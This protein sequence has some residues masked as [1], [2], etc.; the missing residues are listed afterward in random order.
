MTVQFVK[1]WPEDARERGT[2]LVVRYSAIQNECA[3]LRPRVED[4]SQQI[5]D[6]VDLDT[7][8]LHFKDE[9][10]MIGSCLLHPDHVVEQE[11]VAVAW[12]QPFVRER[13]ARHHHFAEL[14]YLRM[15][16][17]LHS[18]TSLA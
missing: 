13:W 7:A 5:L 12:R 9:V 4:V 17:E 2:D 14:A 6:I 15:N 18:Q 8:V 3:A 10:G 16:T 11:I 1:P